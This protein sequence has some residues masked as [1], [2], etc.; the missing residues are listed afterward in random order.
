[1]SHQLNKV[2]IKILSHFQTNTESQNPEST[3]FPCMKSNFQPLRNQLDYNLFCRENSQRIYTPL[4]IRV[5]ADLGLLFGVQIQ[6]R[7]PVADLLKTYLRIKK[8]F[9][10][11]AVAAPTFSR[12]L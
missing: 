7:T 11:N 4:G 8:L 3:H 1:M 5:L 6:P 2:R 10:E 9:L 12:L